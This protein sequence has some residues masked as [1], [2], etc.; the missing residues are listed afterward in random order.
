MNTDILIVGCGVA[1][2]Y[3]AL[4][5]PE[6]RNILIVT[7][8]IA[9]K[10]DSYLAQGGICVL[11]DEEDYDSFYEDTMKA[12]HYENNKKSVDIMINSSREVINDLVKYGAD[13]EKNGDEF[14]YTRRTADE[15]LLSYSVLGQELLREKVSL[16][17]KKTADD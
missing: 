8:N 16:E 17:M 1:G 6:N 15:T 10:S 7:K 4:N 2:L 13:F 14:N 5:F 9:R 12:G 3:C 11:R